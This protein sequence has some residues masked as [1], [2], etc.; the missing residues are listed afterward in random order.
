MRP[1]DGPPVDSGSGKGTGK[2]SPVD[3][4]S[5]SGNY[6]PPVDDVIFVNDWDRVIDDPDIPSDSQDEVIYVNDWDRMVD[7]PDIPS[8]YDE[9][10]VDSSSRSRSPHGS[11]KGTGKGLIVNTGSRKGTGKGTGRGSIVDSGSGKGL[12]VDSGSGKG[13]KGSIVEQGHWQ[14]SN[15]RESG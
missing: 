11:S 13:S 1:T 9:S 15:Y 7:D 8:D 4:G 5:G 6:G 2:G 12:I 3:S 10:E 14:W